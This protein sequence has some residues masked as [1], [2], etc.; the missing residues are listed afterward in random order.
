M[1]RAGVLIVALIAPA[2]FAAQPSWIDESNRNAQILLDVMA[3]YNAE[4][5]SSFGVEGHDTEVFDLKP[6]VLERQEADLEAAI[7]KLQELRSAATD[8]LVRRDLDILIGAAGD[9]KHSIELSRQLT[10]PFFDLGQAVFRGFQDLLDARIPKSRQ[11]AALTRLHRYVGAEKGY[12]PITALA[13][14]R[15]E[16]QAGNTQLI[17]PWVV[18]AQQYLNNQMRYLDGIQKL[19]EGSGLKGWQKDMQTL[20]SQFD[21]YGKW[22]TATVLPRARK[23]NQLPAELYADLLKR[24]GVD[25]DPHEIMARALASYQQ[26]RSEMEPLARRIAEERKWT[27]TDYRDVI[28]ELKKQRIPDDQLLA[29]YTGRLEQIEAI[30]R[31]ENLVTLPTRKAVIRLATPAESAATPAPHIDPPRLVGNTGEPAE[32]VLPTSNPNAAPGSV[33]D[34][35]NYD[36]IAWTLTAHEARP[37]HELQFAGM[38]ER[39]VS[40]ARVVFA[41]NSANVEGYALYAEAVLKKF[42]PPEGQLGALQMRMM[43]EARAFLDPMLNLGLIEPA[44]AKRFLMEEVML[45]EPM[46]KQEV[47]RYTFQA[48]GQATAYFYGY[49]RLNALRTRIE[50]AMAGKFDEHRYHDFIVAQGPLPF[51]L[52]EQAA[53]EEFLKGMP[54]TGQSSQ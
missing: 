17:G 21:E 13:R 10:L 31:R 26:S 37:G 15:Y 3:R 12:E 34:D 48:P 16:E 46:A 30:I 33:M 50:L 5:A 7:A 2:A 6:R 24:F 29:L 27:K 23:T 49:S 39:G 38:L 53:A 35:F 4:S 1:F 44:A 14:A 54:A 20:R 9:R 8:P 40:T 45:S 47:D 32:F 28:R 52:L 51:D 25:M 36:A 18:E 11:K 41:L 22:V 19:L 42:L 43:R